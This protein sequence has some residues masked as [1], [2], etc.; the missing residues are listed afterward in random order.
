MLNEKLIYDLKK[1]GLNE[2]EAKAYLTLTIFGPL[3][4]SYISNKSGVPQ[5]KV[6]EI[7][8]A[9]LS[10]SLIEMWDSRPIR[11]KAVNI[12]NALKNLIDDK[13]RRIEELKVKS[14]TIVSRIKPY[15]Y[16]DNYQ[17]WVS[18]GKRSFFEKL[19]EILM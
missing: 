1:F 2:Y 4:A 19:S 6:Y 12:S 9:L 3:S 7:M 14:Q 10:K 11:F 16:S 15:N 17:M 5:T 18:K 8:H 13:E